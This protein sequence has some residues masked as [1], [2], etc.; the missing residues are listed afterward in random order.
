[1]VTLS[2]DNP[3]SRKYY[4]IRLQRSL[5]TEKKL[6]ETFLIFGRNT[7][8]IYERPKTGTY[9]NHRRNTPRKIYVLDQA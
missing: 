8:Y 2:N 7:L 4:R 1:M 3:T 9:Q 5:Q 6:L